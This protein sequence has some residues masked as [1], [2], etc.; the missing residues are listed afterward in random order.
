M[1]VKARLTQLS[2]LEE[3]EVLWN[4]ESY[5]R[6]RTN[7]LRAPE[8]PGGESSTLQLVA[9]VRERFATR[10]FFDAT[11]GPASARSGLR[12]RVERLQSWAVPEVSSGLPPRLLFY[13]GTFR[14][15]GVIEEIR[16]EWFEF[17]P[18]GAPVRGWI[19]LVLRR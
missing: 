13:W 1:I 6:V 11:E 2:T 12:D 3:F 19:D 16:E 14:F 4:P 7:R 8:T 17:D 5:E 15:R 9:E 18:D 10:L